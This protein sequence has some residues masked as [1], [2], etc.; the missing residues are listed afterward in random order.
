M[1]FS[2]FK[3]VLGLT[4]RNPEAAARRLISVGLPM[5]ARWMVAVLTVVCS[6]ILAMLS[7][8]VFGLKPDQ[9]SPMLLA[10]TSPFSMAG[11]QLF[12]IVL[13]AGLMTFI[14]RIFGGR[15][16]FED[17]LLL[18]VW[19]EMLLLLVQ[20]VQ[21]VVS[22]ILPPLAGLLGVASIVLFLWLTVHFAKALH[23]FRSAFL[24]FLALIATA[25]VTGFTL[26]FLAATL[27]LFPRIS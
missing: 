25:F 6:A 18:V 21:L 14:G 27:G 26:S 11:I 24:V 2:D 20:A 10:L 22:V 7:A 19:I 12:A 3:P 13:A 15:G 23:G 16:R 8:L 4:F 5:Q 1:T 17:A 9:L